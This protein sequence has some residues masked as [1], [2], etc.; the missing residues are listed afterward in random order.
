M[1]SSQKRDKHRKRARERDNIEQCNKPISLRKHTVVSFQLSHTE[2]VLLGLSSRS[3]RQCL[4][5]H[6]CALPLY[7]CTHTHTHTQR[8]RERE[9]T[10]HNI[11]PL[12]AQ[13]LTHTHSTDTHPHPSSL[14]M[15]NGG[16]TK[17]I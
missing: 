10:N 14:K 12:N 17:K 6:A 3:C 15:Q 9:I 11:L 2:S 8:G 13:T 1:S 4:G 16:V 7:V 5:M